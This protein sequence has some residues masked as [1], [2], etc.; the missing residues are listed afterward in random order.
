[1]DMHKKMLR[2]LIPLLYGEN[3]EGIEAIPILAGPLRGKLLPKQPA[4]EQLSMLFGCYEPAVI[5]EILRLP[6]M[7]KIAYDV[8][9]HVGY[10]TLALAH[11]IKNGG[12][13]FAFEPEPANVQFLGKLVTM[14]KL[15]KRVTL[16]PLA[17]ADKKGQH[18]FAIWRS[19]SM[20]Q[21]QSAI[22][23][24]DSALCQMIQVEGSTIDSFV[25]DY[26]NPPPDLIKI[27]VEGAE[28]LVLKGALRTLGVCSPNI[29]IEI[30]GPKN[31]AR[32]WELLHRLKYTW[33][34]LTKKDRSAVPTKENLLSYFAKD[35]WTHH[36]L[37]IKA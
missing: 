6:Q 10:I 21:L 32:V 17:L 12:K 8:G 33:S 14:N 37:L 28:A 31:G 20:H 13:V 2:F 23:G 11:G 18:K 26:E 35:S 7:R 27:D 16:I 5:S 36:F 29:I 15:E 1:M 9:A 19:P 34:M 25:F 22:D 3:M 30:H 4:L 24:Q